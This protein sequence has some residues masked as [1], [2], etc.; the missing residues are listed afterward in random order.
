MEHHQSKINYLQVFKKYSPVI[1]SLHNKQA[2]AG[3]LRTEQDE[4][5]LHR[6]W[7][8]LVLEKAR[9]HCCIGWFWTIPHVTGLPP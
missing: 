3:R 7:Q 9:K 8:H 4:G 1:L 5:W 6:H 2:Y